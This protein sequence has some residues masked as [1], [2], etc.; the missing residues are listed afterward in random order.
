MS[1]ALTV[2]PRECVVARN[3]VAILSFTP[4]GLNCDPGMRRRR[5][6]SNRTAASLDAG[7][8]EEATLQ[9]LRKHALE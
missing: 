4:G 9:K 2:G 8:L 5:G 6:T 7:P 3:R 1:S